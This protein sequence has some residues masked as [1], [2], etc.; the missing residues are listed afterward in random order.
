M[1]GR[2]ESNRPVPLPT[3][4]SLGAASA[5]HL[6]LTLPHLATDSVTGRVYRW[7]LAVEDGVWG[8]NYEEVV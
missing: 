2:I 3:L 6:E 4:E 7:G 8:Y 5:S 1:G